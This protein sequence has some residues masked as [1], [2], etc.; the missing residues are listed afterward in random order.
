MAEDRRD[1]EGCQKLTLLPA[2]VDVVGPGEASPASNTTS[3]K[4]VIASD[5]IAVS[6]RRLGRGSVKERSAQ[7]LP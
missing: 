7:R 1:D 2:P 3:S 4:A 5:A 6:T